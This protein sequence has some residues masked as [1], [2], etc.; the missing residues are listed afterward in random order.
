MPPG[1]QI[2]SVLGGSGCV[3]GA[4]WVVLPGLSTAL[5]RYVCH[6]VALASWLGEV[7]P[8]PQAIQADPRFFGTHRL[9]RS[10]VVTVCSRSSS[11]RP[12]GML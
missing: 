6:G 3:R 9:A 12:A 1:E 8:A 7:T 4:S 11:T 10:T 2:T 5:D